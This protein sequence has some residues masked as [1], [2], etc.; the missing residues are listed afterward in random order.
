MN[1]GFTQGK[2]SGWDYILGPPECEWM[3]WQLHYE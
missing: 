3:Y 1:D 2:P